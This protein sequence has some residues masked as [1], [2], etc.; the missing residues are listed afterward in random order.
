MKVTFSF[1]GSKFQADVPD[2]FKDLPVE[3]QQKRLYQSLQSKYGLKTKPP[4][5]DKNILDYLSLLERPAQALKVGL[6]ET[7]IGSAVHSALGGVDLTPR[8]GFFKGAYRGWMGQ[9][10]IRTQDYLPDDMNPVLKGV[11]GFAGD[12]A[13]DPL[14]F[15]GASGA[16]KVGQGIKKAS[17]VTGATPVL[18]KAGEKILNTDI[19]ENYQVKDLLRNFNVATGK[20]KVVKG[21]A[22]K[23]GETDFNRVVD[24]AM[25]KGLDDLQDLFVKRAQA[26]NIGI[27]NVH[28]AFVKAMERPLKTKNKLDSFG[29]PIQM[30]DADGNPLFKEGTDEPVYQQVKDRGDLG[31]V[32]FAEPID[33]A[34]KNILGENADE[35]VDYWTN[36]FD[37]S[38]KY[39]QA[40]GQPIRDIVTRGYFPRVMTKEWKNTAAEINKVKA[41]TV[42]DEIEPIFGTNYRQE[43]VEIARDKGLYDASKLFEDEYSKVY[44]EVV[45]GAPNPVDAPFFETNP[46]LAMGSRLDQ[47]AKAL[48]KKWFI[49]EITDT[50]PLGP[51]YSANQLA[52]YRAAFLNETGQ[53]AMSEGKDT[54][55]FVRW[56]SNNTPKKQP[57]NIGTWVRER[58]GDD[59]KKIFEKRILNPAWAGSKDLDNDRFLFQ[60][61]NDDEWLQFTRNEKNVLVDSIPPGTFESEIFRDSF[62]KALRDR[63]RDSAT[64]YDELIYMGLSTLPRKSVADMSQY[65]KDAY[66][67]MQESTRQAILKLGKESIDEANKIANASRVKFYAP[68]DLQRQIKDTMD[69]MSGVKQPYEFIRMYDKMQN[70]WKSWSLGVRPAYHTR[71]A[72]GN[73]WNAYMV[74]GVS[75]ADMFKLAQASAKLQYYSRFGGSEAARQK[76]IEQMKGINKT[77]FNTVNKTPLKTIKDSEW[78]APNFEGTGYSMKEIYEQARARGITAG[79]YT[80]DTIKELETS[81]QVRSGE[82]SMLER[83]LGQDN[84]IVRGGFAIGGTIEGNF[85]FQVFLNTLKKIKE[86]PSKYEWLAPDGKKYKMSEKIPKDYFKTETQLYSDRGVAV[87][88]LMT[89]NDIAFD[90]A[91]Q[92][93]K[94]SMFDY[95]DLSSFEQNWAKRFLP[96]YTWT[97]KNLPVQ[98]KS[99][100]Q[101]PQRAEQLAI[102]KQQFEHGAGELD[103]SDY[104]QFWN[105]RVPV[106]LGGEN[107]GVVKA[108]ALMNLIPMA[109][110][111]YMID[112]KRIIGEMATPLIKAP[113][114]ALA[115]YDTFMNKAI[116]STPGQMDDFLGVKLPPRLHHLAKVLVP[117]TEINRLNPGGVFGENILD[118]KTGNTVFK[119]DAYFGLGASR[120]T[121]KDVQEVSRWIRFFS[122]IASYDV[123]LDR[124]KY[125]ENKNLMRDVAELKGRLK[126]AVRKGENRKAQEMYDLLEAVANGETIDP[127]ERR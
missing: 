56:L 105:E 50:G 5:E 77:F 15:F 115:N 69:V 45:G 123:N 82:G 10:E 101:N 59:G 11:L 6:K 42:A 122:G 66:P 112:P 73:A 125:F 121:Y 90:V 89:K 25:G 48:Q 41:D 100:I 120:D 110:L 119:K 104:G 74:S 96:F 116:K 127:F 1:D 57:L 83:Y 40:A 88:K 76:T 64:Q 75:P 8:E 55:E 18:Q 54:P 34:T 58:V 63:F 86:N 20:G 108:F 38:S 97:R 118:P 32:K 102:A 33:E 65:L 30:R 21:A 36:V 103:K 81:L 113:L 24:E 91:S 7:N 3:V 2:N 95:G 72:V 37:L 9:D 67:T 70:A 47:Q 106:F 79:H 17:D 28:E 85:R 19:R 80:R 35:I 107:T 84:P 13:S 44:S 124:N 114:E 43:R 53:Q 99:L 117:L 4:K 109:D 51:V 16:A 23:S 52:D 87:N 68:A 14:T 98:F 27:D 46:I 12:V 22:I 29:K 39:S 94:K 61:M 71:N 49:N 78:T 93:V 92:E 126:W 31:K 111:Q 26:L 60:Q 62:A